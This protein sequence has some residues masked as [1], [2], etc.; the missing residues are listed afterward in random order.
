MVDPGMTGKTAGPR[1]PILIAGGGIGG[2]ALAL[3]LARHGISSQVLE[4]RQAFSEAGAGIQLS[5]NAVDVLERLRVTASLAGS[6]GVP[7]ALLAHQGATGRV[8]QELPLG[9]WIRERHGAPYWLAHRRDLQAALLEAVEREPRIA[10]S[11]GFEIAA[12]E[13]TGE[14]VRARSTTGTLAGGRGL[15]GADGVFSAVRRQLLPDHQPT[16]SGWTAARTVLPASMVDRNLPTDCV[17]VW[18]APRQHVVHYPVRC[19]QEIAVV[20]IT[21]GDGGD[22]GWALPIEATAVGESIA[23][24]APRLKEALGQASAWRRWS[25]YELAPLPFWSQG[26]AT[27]LGDAAHPTLPFLAQGGALA[28][29]DAITLADTLA[30]ATDLEIAFAAYAAARMD[31]SAR[32]VAAARRN[33]QIFHLSGV[34]AAAR[35]LTLALMPP[36]RMMSRYDWVYGWKAGAT[37]AASQR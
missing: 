13:Q 18:L 28:L 2:L 3:A 4:R 14:G 30:R 11:L 35:D 6:A 12:F 21:P 27:L 20:V 5:P 7:R 10:I 34:M 26:A 19:G 29:E 22:Q 15:V 32:V 1:Q 23:G 31:R 33:G 24:F 8:L 9:P 36:G 37:S 25:L 17:G 16:F